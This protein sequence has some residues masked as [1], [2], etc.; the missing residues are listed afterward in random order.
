MQEEEIKNKHFLGDVVDDNIFNQVYNTYHNQFEETIKIKNIYN[1]LVL[2]D[3]DKFIHGMNIV[4]DRYFSDE[5]R[6]NQ[7]FF[8][9][10]RRPA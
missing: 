3:G 8:F 10:R 1:R 4:N 5:Y 7:V 2:F 6:C 9:K